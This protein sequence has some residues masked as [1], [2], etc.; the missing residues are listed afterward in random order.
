[1]R[2]FVRSR[3]AGTRTIG[4]QRRKCSARQASTT[5]AT[6]FPTNLKVELGLAAT[7]FGDDATPS[8][9]DHGGLDQ[10]SFNRSLKRP[11]RTIVS[12]VVVARNETANYVVRLPS[13]RALVGKTIVV[14]TGSTDARRAVNPRAGQ[15][16]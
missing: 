7:I 13:V 8:V 15:R 3:W 2:R 11:R 14:D 4:A 9:L 12:L 5:I 16:E 10:L 1:M 6:V